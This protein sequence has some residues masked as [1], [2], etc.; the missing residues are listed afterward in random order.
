MP[1]LSTALDVSTAKSNS[2]SHAKSDRPAVLLPC[3]YLFIFLIVA[4][5]VSF[6]SLVNTAYRRY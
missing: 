2:F 3:F 1:L 6:S 5:I 4:A